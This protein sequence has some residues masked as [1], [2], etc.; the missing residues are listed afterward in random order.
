MPLV[1]GAVADILADWGMIGKW[2]RFT[3]AFRQVECLHGI[4]RVSFRRRIVG[5]AG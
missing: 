5:M 2:G 3:C 4:S 1:Y